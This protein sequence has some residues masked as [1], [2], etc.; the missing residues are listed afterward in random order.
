[1]GSPHG[2]LMANVFMSSLEEKLHN[3][4]EMPDF[5][6]RFVD[7]SF[8]IM[9]D[10]DPANSFLSIVNRLHPSFASLSFTMEMANDPPFLGPVVMKSGNMLATKVYRKPTNTGF[11][12]QCTHGRSKNNL[13]LM[14]S[15][16]T[17]FLTTRVPF[18]IK[19]HSQ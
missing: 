19:G 5:Y 14:L 8:S 15:I 4:G 12:D 16:G 10:C 2:P 3:T 11:Q 9:P 1:M 13:K 6:R 18:S 7:D 17:F